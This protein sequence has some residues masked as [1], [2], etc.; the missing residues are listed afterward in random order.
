MANVYR[1]RGY[2]TFSR[3]YYH[4]DGEY[5]SYAEAEAEAR[6]RLQK[7]EISQP[8]KHSGGQDGIQD[9]VYIVHSDGRLERV[10]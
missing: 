7:L 4:L 10:R 8:S 9:R 5:S 3:E 1:L 2:D 6:K